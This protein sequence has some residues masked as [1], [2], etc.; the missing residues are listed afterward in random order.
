MSS[1]AD[2]AKTPE[3]K[4]TLPA[5]KVIWKMIRYRRGLWLGNWLMMMLLMLFLQIPALVL[6]E[7]FDT[8]SKNTQAGM[9][10][11]TIVALLFA[12]E[13]GNTLGVYGLITTNTPFFQN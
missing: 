4:R 10:L 1:I 12:A 11:W 9:N 5:W 7:F 3:T 8:L 2:T 13:V 6:R